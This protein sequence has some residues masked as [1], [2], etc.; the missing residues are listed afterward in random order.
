MPDTSA[1]NGQ[2]EQRPGENLY[3]GPYEEWNF[4]AGRDFTFGA[5]RETADYLTALAE[6]PRKRDGEP[7]AG[8]G[9]DGFDA[10]DSEG[11]VGFW[12]TTEWTPKDPAKKPS[13]VPFVLKNTAGRN[14]NIEGLR[15]ILARASQ[16]FS[17]MSSIEEPRYRI[18][19]PVTKRA[20]NLTDQLSDTAWKPDPGLR[21]RIGGKRITVMAVIDDGIPFAHRN[22]RG[23]DGTR[24]RL[25]FCWLQSATGVGEDASPVRFGRE[26]TRECIDGLIRDFGHDEDLLYRE[27]KA[28]DDTEGFGAA[29]DR[30][31]SHGAHVMDLATGFAP[32]RGEEPREDIRVIAVQLPSTIAWDTS[33]FGKDM[34]MLAAVHYIFE[35]AQR[36]AEA[37]KEPNLRLVINFS[38]GFSGGRHDGGTELEAAIHELVAARRCD[39]S[40][41]AIVLPAG[42]MFL[43]R[44]HAR[45]DCL[46]DGRAV[47]PWRVQPNDRTSSYL[48]IWFGREFAPGGWVV[49]LVDPHG[50]V[51]GCATIEAQEGVKGGDPIKKVPLGPE[52]APTGQMTVDRHRQGRWRVLV[53]LAPTEVDHLHVESTRAAEAGLWNVIIRREDGS[54]DLPEP[55]ECWIQRDSDPEPLRS[56][57]RQSYF[58]DP[59]NLRYANDGSP[60]ETDSKAS[61]VRRFGSL[62]GLAT[63]KTT[64]RVAGYRRTARQDWSPGCAVAAHYSSA[65]PMVEDPQC[66]AQ[67][68]CASLTDRSSVLAGTIAAGTRS[69]AMSFLQGTSAAAPFVARRLAAAFAVAAEK[70]LAAAEEDNYLALLEGGFQTDETCAIDGTRLGRIVIEPHW[71]PGEVRRPA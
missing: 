13:F 37:Y 9:Q 42:N 70:D 65:G 16:I 35:R 51:K 64:T 8:D 11:D 14:L 43:D 7:M 38:Y 49:E 26:F 47:L 29:I 6:L 12:R 2:N 48:E 52:A 68:D 27:S 21:R 32:Q 50:T 3:L 57:S 54:N 66:H 61:V 31:M 25:E 36:I 30:H 22:F 34:Y 19:F 1:N 59:A 71:Q 63:A 58:D 24:T 17:P 40:P 53:A 39:G 56:G 41:T 33:G 15:E 5:I 45:I 18:A 55:I 20:M 28:R 60:L 46:H 10:S 4:G 69:G 44:M 62:N 23:P 67:V